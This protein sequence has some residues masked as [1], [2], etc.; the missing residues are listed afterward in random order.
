MNKVS[1]INDFINFESYFVQNDYFIKNS[2]KYNYNSKE[3][4]FKNYLKIAKPYGNPEIVAK[5]Y[6]NS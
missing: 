1:N 4:D 3:K 6:E 2:D 5:S